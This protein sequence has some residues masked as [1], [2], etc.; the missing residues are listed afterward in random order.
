MGHLPKNE[1]LHIQTKRIER[2][3]NR[4]RELDSGDRHGTSLEMDVD[5]FLV[6]FSSFAFI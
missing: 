2:W 6:F 5:E 1:G 3:Y 4:I